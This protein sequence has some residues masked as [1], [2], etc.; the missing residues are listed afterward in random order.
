MKMCSFNLF[1]EQ[2]PFT[3]FTT[4]GRLAE[5]GTALCVPFRP[6]SQNLL[7]WGRGGGEGAVITPLKGGGWHGQTSLVE[8]HLFLV[9]TWWLPS[10]PQV[11]QSGL[12]F[13][14]Q[15]DHLVS[16]PPPVTI[17]PGV[18]QVYQS[19]VAYPFNVN[20]FAHHLRYYPH[21]PNQASFSELL[22]WYT[23]PPRGTPWGVV[24]PKQLSGPAWETFRIPS[25]V[26]LVSVG[27]CQAPQYR[28]TW[29]KNQYPLAVPSVIPKVPTWIIVWMLP[30]FAF[31]PVITHLAT[32]YNAAMLQ[33][34]NAS[35]GLGNQYF[36]F[37]SPHPP[38]F[39]LSTVN[40]VSACL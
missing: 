15:N 21:C 23:P 38:I 9:W 12:H 33:C 3:H 32:S 40:F 20:T 30:A 17:N 13:V 4:P 34:Y 7:K 2:A 28:P 14:P 31:F 5:R 1:I 18:Q 26:P 35:E 8:N 24:I 29:K 25:I 16:G 6:V 27:S 11:A 22:L 19:D 10:L 39:A 37:Q 36:P